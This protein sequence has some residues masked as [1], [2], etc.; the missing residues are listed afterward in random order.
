MAVLAITPHYDY[1][2]TA[3]DHFSQYRFQTSNVLRSLLKMYVDLHQETSLLL[4]YE[5]SSIKNAL[6]SMF[7]T[8]VCVIFLI[9]LR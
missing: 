5:T 1:T 4:A 8:A 3:A 2:R 9:K 7:I 6:E